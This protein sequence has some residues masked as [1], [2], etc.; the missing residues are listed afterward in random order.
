MAVWISFLVLFFVYSGTCLLGFALQRR[1]VKPL[2]WRWIHHVLFGSIVLCWLVCL[3]VSFWQ[4]F[5]H[6]YPLLL[7]LPIWVVFPRLRPYQPLHGLAALLG[8]VWLVLVA[9][10]TQMLHVGLG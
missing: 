8:W 2:R 4:E 10:L 3:A 9:V 1:W 6:F 5:V 7:L